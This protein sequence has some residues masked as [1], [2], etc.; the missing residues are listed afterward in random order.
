MR[1]DAVPLHDWLTRRIVLPA[2]FLAGRR[3]VMRLCRDLADGERDAPDVLAARRLAKLRRLLDHAERH[4]P[5]HAA[6][7]AAAGLRAADLRSLDDLAAYPLLDKSDLPALAASLGPLAGAVRRRS[8]GTAGLPVEVFTS[9][10]AHASSI[11]ARLNCYRWYGLQPGAREVRFWGRSLT[12]PGLSAQLR[13]LLL[14][15]QLVETRDLEPPRIERTLEKI[16]ASGAGYAYGYAS[17]IARF[18][19]HV[20]STGRHEGALGLRLAVVTAEMSGAAERR[21]IAERLGCPVADEYG[22][23]EVDI[24]TF[25]CP[26]GGRHVIADNI[27]LEQLP[28]REAGGAGELVVTDLNN[29]TMPLIRYRL[30]DL[31]RL[32]TGVCACGRTWPLLSAV[33]GRTRKMFIRRRDGSETHIAAFVYKMEEEREA[34]FPLRQFQL[35]QTDYERFVVN[36]VVST[37]G[38]V[39]GTGLQRR[40]E[41]LLSRMA[42]TPCSCELRTLAE[43]P[44][45]EGRKLTYFVDAVD[46]RGNGST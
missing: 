34:G 11:A 38:A 39:D 41:D 14:N 6:R 13:N 1:G 12:A 15:R 7:F 9:R 40:L 31:G 46:G 23:S 42:G 17:L 22:C 30:G 2:Y 32:A 27:L 25:Q 20:E 33:D 24:I 8:A 3:P 5:F 45:E 19:A 18:A 43:I 26:E 35:V 36:I 37:S 44:R 21:W 10:E 28:A 29:L 16:A 4:V